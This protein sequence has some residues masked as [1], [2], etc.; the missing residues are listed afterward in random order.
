VSLVQALHEQSRAS[1]G[2]QKL[3]DLENAPVDGFG[4]ALDETIEFPHRGVAAVVAVEQMREIGG[5]PI[6][7]SHAQALRR[8][9]LAEEA[10]KGVELGILERRIE[11]LLDRMLGDVARRAYL[12]PTSLPEGLTPGL[13]FH[14]TYDPPPMTY[15]NSAHACE[16]EV[17]VATGAIRIERYVI[18]EDCGTLLNPTAVE[19]QQHGAVRPRKFYENLRRI[20]IA[21]VFE[22]RI[23]R[24]AVLQLKSAITDDA[25]QKFIQL[26]GCRHFIRDGHLLCS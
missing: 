18:A 9:V 25:F 16:I 17:D 2:G 19:G 10:F 1:V 24:D 13:E 7:D 3:G 15:S 4:G 14:L 20:P 26:V 22:D 8:P 23:H 11:R 5:D 21:V 12:D 6:E